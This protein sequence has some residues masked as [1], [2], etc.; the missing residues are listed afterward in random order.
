MY[1]LLMWFNVEDEDFLKFRLC[2]LRIIMFV[3]MI[4][5]NYMFEIIKIN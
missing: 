3:F 2:L 4:V 1:L 5:L